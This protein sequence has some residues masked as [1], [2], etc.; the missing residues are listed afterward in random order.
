M[1]YS[2]SLVTLNVFSTDDGEYLNEDIYKYIHANVFNSKADA[3]LVTKDII[4]F[5]GN[6]VSLNTAKRLLDLDNYSL[7]SFIVKY[8][9][10][11]A[12][13]KYHPLTLAKQIKKHLDN[14][15]IRTARN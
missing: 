4:K 3:E 8:F 6:T 13:I 12:K 5:V 7:V 1:S 11:H 9:N 14:D 15:A 10:V 2:G